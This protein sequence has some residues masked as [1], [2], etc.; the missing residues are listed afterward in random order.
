MIELIIDKR[1]RDLGGGFEVGRILPF[2]KKH[3]VGPFIFLDHMGP[4][5]IAAGAPR[6]LDVRPHPHIGLSTVTYLFEGRITHR[7]SLGFHQEIRPREVNWM[8]AGSGIT[9]SERFDYARQH[10]A[11]IHG[12]Q[13]W[14]AL[15]DK[16]EETEPSFSHYEGD[17]LPLWEENGVK[18]CLIAGEFNGLTAKAQVYSPMFYVHLDLSAASQQSI[19]AQCS[20]RAVYIV[21]G[22]VHIGN[23][24]LQAGQMAVLT[25]GIDIDVIAD[26]EATIMLLGGEPIGERY[27]FWNFVSSS[28]TIINQ[29]AEDW[30]AQ[31]MKLPVDDDQEFIP[32]PAELKLSDRS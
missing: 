24:I 20:E 22:S 19:P 1:T 5:N 25:T 7:D 13:A 28:K 12:M 14:V 16:L 21:K 31:R 9:H 4:V 6:E 29:A 10:G 11:T 18:G 26:K 15:P 30:R 8:V 17:D 3:M 27:I 23:T 32:L 2:A